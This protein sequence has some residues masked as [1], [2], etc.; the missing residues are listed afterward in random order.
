MVGASATDTEIPYLFNFPLNKKGPLIAKSRGRTGC[1][2]VMDG[3]LALGPTGSGVACLQLKVMLTSSVPP[4]SLD[5]GVT[6]IERYDSRSVMALPKAGDT[7]HAALKQARQSLTVPVF[8]HKLRM[9]LMRTFDFFFADLGM[10]GSRRFRAIG[11]LDTRP[12]GALAANFKPSSGNGILLP[13][14][15][16][17]FAQ[18][19][20]ILIDVYFRALQDLIKNNSYVLWSFARGSGCVVYVTYTGMPGLKCYTAGSESIST[21]VQ[22]ASVNLLD[23]NLHKVSLVVSRAPHPLEAY[24]YVDGAQVFQGSTTRPFSITNSA[25]SINIFYD[26][27]FWQYRPLPA[28]L[29]RASVLASQGLAEISAVAK[30]LAFTEIKPWSLTNKFKLVPKLTTE[31]RHCQALPKVNELPQGL[32]CTLVPKVNGK[33]TAVPIDIFSLSC[34]RPRCSISFDSR[35][36]TPSTSFVFTYKPNFPETF[37]SENVGSPPLFQ[38]PSFISDGFSTNIAS[39]GL[40]YVPEEASPDESKLEIGVHAGVGDVMRYRALQSCC[41]G[42]FGRADQSQLPVDDMF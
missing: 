13:L 2:K 9:T 22:S 19:N 36:T 24:L 8:D 12:N 40:E 32:R 39:F 38:D 1:Y 11:N 17:D 21:Q 29:V 27:Y 31:W 34:S 25:Q 6:T 41:A 28:L 35:P 33:V 26:A 30:R 18:Y 3:Q 10:S 20:W 7:D 15:R 23:G 42:V 37:D 5:V 16:D 4:E 14:E